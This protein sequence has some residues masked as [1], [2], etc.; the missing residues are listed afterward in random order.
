MECP[1]ACSSKSKSEAYERAVVWLAHLIGGPV[2]YIPARLEPKNTLA[3][4]TKAREL[5]GW[6]PEVAL[7]DG[8]AELKKEWGIGEEGSR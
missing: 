8:I 2:T 5:L 3:D 1:S 4:N 7:A 6:I